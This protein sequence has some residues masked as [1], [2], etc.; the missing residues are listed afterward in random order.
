MCNWTQADFTRNLTGYKNQQNINV[1]MHIS[2]TK[3]NVNGYLL[4]EE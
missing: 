1:L 3:K 4:L 2:E